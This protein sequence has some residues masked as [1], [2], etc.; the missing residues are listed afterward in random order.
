MIENHSNSTMVRCTPPY[1]DPGQPS[2]DVLATHRFQRFFSKNVFNSGIFRLYI[3]IF[4]QFIYALT[5]EE[6]RV[7]PRG[8]HGLSCV[9]KSLFDLRLNC[10]GG[11]E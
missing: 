10:R 9:V 8:A 2:S 11:A 1:L 7:I 6:L 3:E 5:S 4:I